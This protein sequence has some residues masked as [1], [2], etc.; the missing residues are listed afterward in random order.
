MKI[1]KTVFY[2]LVAAFWIVY[3]SLLSAD[4]KKDMQQERLEHMRYQ[5]EL[6]KKAEIYE[7]N[8]PNGQEKYYSTKNKSSAGS[9]EAETKKSSSYSGNSGQNYSRH[10]ASYDNSAEDFADD[11]YEEFYD[12][13]D[14]YEDYDEAYDAAMDYWEDNH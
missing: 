10:Y 6:R 13:E 9:S 8:H 12:S 4:V 7:R 5:E 11:F 1:V 3:I 14:D 2:V